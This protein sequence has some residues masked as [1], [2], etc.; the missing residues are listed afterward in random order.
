MSKERDS[1]NKLQPDPERFPNGIKSLADQ[2]HSMGLKLGIYG[3]Y[4]S[5]TCAGY[6]GSIDNLELDA[7]V[8]MIRQLY[9]FHTYSRPSLTG[10]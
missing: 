7:Q 1:N 9:R 5:H 4:G 10:G 8:N 6:P 3:D 2:L